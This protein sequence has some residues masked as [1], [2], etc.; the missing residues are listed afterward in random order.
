MLLAIKLSLLH[1][2]K[3]MFL[4]QQRWLKWGWW[5][6]YIYAVAWAIAATIYLI[7][8]CTPVPY[9]WEKM[10]AKVHAN[11]PHPIK[12]GSCKNGNEWEVGM[13]FVF[14]LVSDLGILLL[15]TITLVKLQLPRKK[16]V[17]LMIIFSFGLM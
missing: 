16:K 11:P 8:Q 5:I 15:P 9:Y 2:Y 10:W 7:W 14:S 4:V 1:L 3:R 12:V 13:P 6:N 17:G